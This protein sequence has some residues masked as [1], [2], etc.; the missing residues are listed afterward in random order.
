MA[1]INREEKW[2]FVREPHTASRATAAALLTIPHSEE[3]LPQHQSIL[4]IIPQENVLGF[5]VICSVRNPL[6]V[7]VSRWRLGKGHTLSFREW[8]L[9][10]EAEL[11]SK[12]FGH[13]QHSNIV[14]WFE[15]LHHDYNYV[16]DLTVPIEHDPRHKTLDKDDWSSYYDRDTFRVVT[17]QYDD[18][19]KEFGY[20]LS[21]ANGR[22]T[23]QIDEPAR[24]R[25]LQKIGYGRR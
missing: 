17:E 12:W 18:Y 13:W 11:K 2:V 4:D 23:V 5:D 14:C 22:A 8:V 19:I 20:Q 15:R 24:K 7:V 10:P 16:F 1:V 21:F 9:S 3:L 6:D 25:R